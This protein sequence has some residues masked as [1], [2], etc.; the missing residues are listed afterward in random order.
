MIT[1]SQLSPDATAHPPH[2]QAAPASDAPVNQFPAAP[3][4]V[5]P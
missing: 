5:N 1:L 2:L 4:A 3:E